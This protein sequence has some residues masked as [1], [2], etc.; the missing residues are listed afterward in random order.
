M[1]ES[2]TSASK[3]S[4]GRRPLSLTT[5]VTVFVALAIGLSL[6]FI[7]HLILNAV[8]HHFAEQD[9]EE[10]QV[11]TKA[12]QRVLLANLEDSTDL[13]EALSKAI[14]GH[15]GV[16]FEVQNQ[17]GKILYTSFDG[18]VST[19]AVV[20]ADASTI[21]PAKLLSWRMNDTTLRGAVSH[22]TVAGQDFRVTTAIDMDFHLHFLRGFR[23]S[24]WLIMCLAG[25]VTLCAAWL[26]VRQG[27]APVRELSENLRTIHADRLSVRLDPANVPLELQ[28]LVKSFNFMLG[29]LEESFIRLTNFS[30]DI[31]HE[32]RTPLTNIIT[33]TQVGL[34]KVRSK[35]EYRELL[36]SNLEEQERLAKMVNDMLW[37]AKTDRGLIK[38]KFEALDL[39]TEVQAIL[40]FFE[41]LAEEENIQLR[42]QGRAPKILGDRAMLRRAVSNLL[43]NALRYT[44]SGEQITVQ[45]ATKDS[46]EVALSVQNTGSEIPAELQGKLFDRFY[47]ADPARARQSEGA[48]LGLAITKSIVD[49]HGGRVQVSS[50]K[51]LTKFIL[52]FPP[53][54]YDLLLGIN[55]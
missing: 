48:G 45:L 32:L 12:I 52:I 31:A 43:S 1:I 17:A 13:A 25:L 4:T 40:E 3:T 46:G 39:A 27:H 16:Y 8:H 2:V 15:H 36:Y 22:I 11:M 24:L 51:E 23:H 21:D 19:Q 34:S 44:K 10:L 9:A 18:G 47:R 55:D 54:G 29:R 35:E 30:A 20:S 7:S 41:A 38:P 5:R 50:D 42:L 49:V 53:M 33:Q 28:Y 37:L 6:L 26:G 14:S